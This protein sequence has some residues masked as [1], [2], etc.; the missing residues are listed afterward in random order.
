MSAGH[1]INVESSGAFGV[2]F[3]FVMFWGDPDIADAIIHWL[4]K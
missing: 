1:N 4:M 3:W 2:A